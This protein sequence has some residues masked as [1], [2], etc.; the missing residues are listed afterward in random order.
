MDERVIDPQDQSALLR[1]WIDVRRQGRYLT[2]H[3]HVHKTSRSCCKGLD[4]DPAAFA[5]EKYLHL[6]EDQN[7]PTIGCFFYLSEDN[8]KDIGDVRSRWT[9]LNRPTI[10]NLD[11]KNAEN[12]IIY[13]DFRKVIYP[14]PDNWRRD[15]SSVPLEN[16]HRVH[17]VHE[18][19]KVLNPH[20]GAICIKFPNKICVAFSLSH[21]R[22]KED[23]NAI[24]E[25]FA[26]FFSI[27]RVTD[28]EKTAKGDRYV[29][30]RCLL[31]HYALLVVEHCMGKK[32]RN[33]CFASLPK[34]LR[35]FFSGV[36]GQRANQDYRTHYAN[37]Q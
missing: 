4:R 3:S 18:F 13:S 30:E 6:I 23:M 7:E 26:H 12:S 36:V 22:Y 31:Y 10:V 33:Q 1:K 15:L 34:N 21:V 17:L 27:L 28:Y 16:L 24:C 19:D 5:V 25:S 35:K 11:F 8:L 29:I 9:E 37:Y 20:A 2:L 14:L 32:I